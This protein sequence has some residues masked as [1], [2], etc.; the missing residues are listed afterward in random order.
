VLP[1]SKRLTGPKLEEAE[2]VQRELARRA[3]KNNPLQFAASV[4]FEQVVGAAPQ[5]WQ[6]R[7]IESRARR[8]ILNCPRQSGKSTIAALKALHR[9]VYWPGSTIL[10][11]SPTQRQSQELLR[12]VVS[13][14]RQ[15]GSQT[16]K[17][18]AESL[19]ML[20]LANGS[21][22]ISL[23]SSESIRGYTAALVIEDEAA[24]VPDETYHAVLP[25]IAAS[26]GDY[27]MMGT[28]KGRRGHFFQAWENGGD[29]WERYRIKADDVAHLDKGELSAQKRVLG[30]LYAR[31]Y[32]GEFV[33]AQ[34]GLVYGRFDRI[35]NALPILPLPLTAPQWRYMLGVDFGYT[36]DATALVVVGW[37]P[38]DPTLYVIQ[39]EKLYGVTAADIAER[40]KKFPFKFSRIVA[41][42]LGRG[43]ETM[44]HIRRHHHLPFEPAEDRQ[45]KRGWIELLNSDYSQASIK[46]YEPANAALIEEIVTLPWNDDRTKEVE[47]YDNHLCDALL[48]VWKASTAY[49]QKPLAP[50]DYV[51]PSLPEGQREALAAAKRFAHARYSANK[52][53]H[54]EPANNEDEIESWL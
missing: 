12:R 6:T 38:N 16:I 23:P 30:T 48:Y 10:C 11:I 34:G 45:N 29:A 37:I 26:H 51:D 24:D 33:E 53:H 49:L 41:D 25:M 8:A 18:D 22:I 43:K 27:V 3:G 20:E 21:R 46:I 9:A 17:L 52:Q 5:Q 54:D 19:S 7:F 50:V 15:A 13:F 4:G 31:E 32:E 40:V 36:R 28:P 1:Q 2:K 39:S 44:D 42:S 14:L 47:N 35:R